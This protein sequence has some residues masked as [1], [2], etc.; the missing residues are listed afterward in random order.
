MRSQAGG[1]PWY[2]VKCGEGVGIYPFSQFSRESEKFWFCWRCLFVWYGVE[3]RSG[4]SWCCCCGRDVIVRV[5]VVGGG[6][7][8]GVR[9]RRGCN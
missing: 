2:C 7:G 3:T 4:T 5:F 9:G 6:V 8:G 1:G